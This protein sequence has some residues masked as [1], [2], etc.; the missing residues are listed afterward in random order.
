MVFLGS[1]GKFDQI[2]LVRLDPQ[3]PTEDAR[4][5]TEQNIFTGDLEA[6]NVFTSNVGISNLFPH[7]NFAVG[8]NVWINDEGV[9]TMSVKKRAQF[10][11]AR[12]SSQMSVNT[13]TPTHIFQVNDEGKRVFVDNLGADLFNVEGNVVCENLRVTQGMDMSGDITTTGNVTASRIIFDQG[14]EF[15]SNIVIDDIGDPVLGITGNVDVT[16]VAARPRVAPHRA[17]MRARLAAVLGVDADV[18]SVK[19]TTT[20]GLG[21]IG[22]GEGIAAW[23]V[24]VLRPTVPGG[25]AD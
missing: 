24:A 6:S 19:A 7:H 5:L 10:E 11:Q 2:T 4:G 12:V 16:V 20:D 3:A 18:V 14:L 22:R 21:S 1:R 23:A 25:R 8:S 13:N 15:G 17:A 9:V